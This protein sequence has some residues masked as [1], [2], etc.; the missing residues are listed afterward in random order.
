E[1][2]YAA[3]GRWVEYERQRAGDDLVWDGDFQFGD[4]LAYA[5]PSREARSYPGATTS[6]DL[7][8]TAFFAHSADLMQRIARVLGREEDAGRYAKLFSS[9]AEAFRAEYLSDRGRVGE[10]TQTAYVLALEFDLLPEAARPTAAARLA[11]EVRERK[12]LTTGFLGTPY[13]CHVL[14]R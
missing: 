13:L 7:I 8:A 3:M 1:D 2:Q 9:V 11:R 5:A 12:H 6:K 10:A 4:W 14:T